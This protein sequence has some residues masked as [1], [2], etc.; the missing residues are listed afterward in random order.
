MNDESMNKRTSTRYDV[1]T[2]EH[3]DLRIAAGQYIHG[4][5]K[6]QNLT[7]TQL[8]RRLGLEFHTFVSQVETGTRRIPPEE[9]ATWAKALNT[10][11]QTFARIL[12][13]FYDPVMHRLVFRKELGV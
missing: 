1:K 3:R 13:K 2:K 11:V 9:I 5:R 12:F 4:L 10:D 6:A 7:Q 8:A